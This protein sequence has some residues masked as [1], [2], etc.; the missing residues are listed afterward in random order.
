VQN[1]VTQLRNFA[2]SKNFG[3]SGAFWQFA[4][5]WFRNRLADGLNRYYF[6]NF[7]GSDWSE[8]LQLRNWTEMQCAKCNACVGRPSLAV[9]ITGSFVG[10][11]RTSGPVHEQEVA[12][13]LAIPASLHKQALVFCMLCFIGMIVGLLGTW[14]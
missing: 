10:T 3:K 13:P 12:L 2:K 7:A 5:L 4:A 11:N 14:A 6:G 8:F 9:L 1:S